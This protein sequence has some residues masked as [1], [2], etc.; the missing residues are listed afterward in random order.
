MFSKI[1]LIKY[2]IIYKHKATNYYKIYIQRAENKRVCASR[3]INNNIQTSTGKL[4]IEYILLFF[5][6][7][8]TMELKNIYS[9]IQEKQLNI[10]VFSSQNRLDQV[11]F[12]L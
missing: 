9:A 4:L 7:N 2:K 5:L 10:V 11:W 6:H 12:L 3:N 8:C 1:R